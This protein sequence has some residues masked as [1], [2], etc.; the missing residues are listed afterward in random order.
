MHIPP[1]GFE[2]FS[3][4]VRNAEAYTPRA[5]LCSRVRP[6]PGMHVL[7][8]RKRGNGE[9]EKRREE[10][11]ENGKG[12]SSPIPRFSGSPILV[13]LRRSNLSTVVTAPLANVVGSAS[14]V[15]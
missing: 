3:S 15:V 5:I 6:E 9:R 10:A 4:S 1:L 8:R 12:K 11:V 13:S 14:C 7:Y 2:E